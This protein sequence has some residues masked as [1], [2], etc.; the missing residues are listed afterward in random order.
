MFA[1][2]LL[3][4]SS[5]IASLPKTTIGNAINIS[6]ENELQNS[7]DS[8]IEKNNLI[9]LDLFISWGGF[10]G[11]NYERSLADFISLE[12]GIAPSCLKNFGIIIPVGVNLFLPFG[13]KH[14][15]GGTA[16]LF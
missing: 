11:L 1:I 7:A 6:N 15:I 3:S 14:N 5:T 13:E 12:A 8:L 2:L 4:V 16:K 10:I 9:T